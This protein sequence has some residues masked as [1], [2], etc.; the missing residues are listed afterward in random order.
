MRRYDAEGYLLFHMRI[1]PAEQGYITITSMPEFDTNST[2][3]LQR[4]LNWLH[5]H[6]ILFCPRLKKFIKLHETLGIM[7]DIP[8]EQAKQNNFTRLYKTKVEQ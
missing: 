4:N 6:G 5:Q 1:D 2:S 7:L 3:V 8:F